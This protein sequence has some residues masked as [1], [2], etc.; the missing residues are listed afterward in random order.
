[1]SS[2][3]SAARTDNPAVAR[4]SSRVEAFLISFFYGTGHCGL[5]TMANPVRLQLFCPRL[6]E[7]RV[8]IREATLVPWL[9]SLRFRALAVSVEPEIRRSSSVRPFQH[10]RDLHLGTTLAFSLVR[11]FH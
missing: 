3:L 1:M 7:G 8:S 4:P 11:R 6:E 10:V 5:K 2:F 9:S